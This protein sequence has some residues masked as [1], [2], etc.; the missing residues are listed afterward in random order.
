MKT[1]RV[2]FAKHRQ[3]YIFPI[4]V[5]TNTL[6]G[7]FVGIMQPLPCQDEFI[8]FYSKSLLVSSSTQSA[9]AILH[10]RDGCD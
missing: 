2:S 7:S 6:D 1:T 8:F 10:V 3:G 9:M 4:V 5:N